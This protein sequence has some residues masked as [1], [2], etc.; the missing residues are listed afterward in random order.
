MSNMAITGIAATTTDT[1]GP[2]TADDHV[3]IRYVTNLDLES[4]T[5]ITQTIQPMVTIKGVK[6]PI[7]AAITVASGITSDGIY[8]I[9]L[10]NKD[11]VIVSG[12][13]FY[14]K[15]VT[16]VTGDSVTARSFVSSWGR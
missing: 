13:E 9:M 8:Q 4:S 2:F 10:R 16:T 7:H 12:R 6:T 11:S 3:N 14:I 15:R 1:L 5:T